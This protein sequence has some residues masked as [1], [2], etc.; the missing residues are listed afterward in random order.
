MCRA[1]DTLTPSSGHRGKSHFA[2][3]PRLWKE[4]LWVPGDEGEGHPQRLQEQ[5]GAI[6]RY[7]H[8]CGSWDGD[9]RT[10]SQ[11]TSQ[12]EFQ[13]HPHLWRPRKRRTG[14]LLATRH[15]PG[16]SCQDRTFSPTRRRQRHAR[17]IAVFRCDQDE[18]QTPMSKETDPKR[19]EKANPG[20]R[21]NWEQQ[22][23]LLEKHEA[24]CA[25]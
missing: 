22:N 14:E 19:R 20:L 17:E 10:M 25:Q 18:S 4:R 12:E 7:H 21:N 5:E 2:S 9:S 8:G 3:L 13:V 24:R 6:P 1:A 15:D 16:A 11:P 23:P